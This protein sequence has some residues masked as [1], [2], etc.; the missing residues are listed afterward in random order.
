[1]SVIIIEDISIPTEVEVTLGIADTIPVHGPGL[2]HVD[3][4]IIPIAPVAILGVGHAVGAEIED[5]KGVDIRAH[6][7]TAGRGVIVVAAPRADGARAVRWGGRV[8]IR[9]RR[10]SFGQS[11]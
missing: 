8:L 9:R 6:G 5:I 2:T 3:A 4:T 11:R 1:M 7:P 10:S